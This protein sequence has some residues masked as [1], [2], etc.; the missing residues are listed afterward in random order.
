LFSTYDLIELDKDFIGLPTPVW[1]FNKATQKPGES[2]VYWNVYRKDPKGSDAYVEWHPREGLQKV[3]A[4]GTGCFIVA[5][6][7][8]LD[9][10]MQQGPFIRKTYPDGRVNKGND[11]S[12]CERMRENGW[13]VWAHLDYDTKNKKDRSL[14]AGKGEV[15][16]RAIDPNDASSYHHTTSASIAGQLRGGGIASG[17]P[18]EKAIVHMQ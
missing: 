5:R 6:K 3:D 11:I 15:N 16:L 7:V 10:K 1:H 12:F 14:K 18:R 13:E 17:T 8:F 9:P 4:V 2:P